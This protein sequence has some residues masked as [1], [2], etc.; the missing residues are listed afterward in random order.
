LSACFK[1]LAYSFRIAFI[2]PF[3]IL[4][5][6]LISISFPFFRLTEYILYKNEKKYVIS[7]DAELAAIFFMAK[8]EFVSFSN[9]ITMIYSKDYEKILKSNT[10]YQEILDKWQSPKY[11]K[12]LKNLAV[13]SG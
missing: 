9:Y 12:I 5:F 2:L 10:G 1:I 6:A 13:K 11:Q 3:S 7:I 8:K 4:K